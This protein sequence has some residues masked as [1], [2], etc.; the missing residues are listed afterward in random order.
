MRKKHKWS[1]ESDLSS[2]DD[3]YNDNDIKDQDCLKFIPKLCMIKGQSCSDLYDYSLQGRAEQS[4]YYR[5]ITTR[6]SRAEYILENLV[7]IDTKM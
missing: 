7:F 1:N 3:T 2:N 4:T 5:S 6:E